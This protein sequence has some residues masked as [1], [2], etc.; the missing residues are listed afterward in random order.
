MEIG[1]IGR[2]INTY[3][4]VWQHGSSRAGRSFNGLAF[5]L[6][7]EQ[8]KSNISNGKK[9]DPRD[10]TEIEDN[11]KKSEESATDTDI[12]VRSDGSRVLVMTTSIGRMT[13]SVSLKISDSTKMPNESSETDITEE[14]Q[15]VRSWNESTGRSGE[16]VR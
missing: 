13:T 9:V 12:V 16:N 14:E 3:G 15:D 1:N 2:N 8:C 4:S 10:A 6:K 7:E 11:E 5:E